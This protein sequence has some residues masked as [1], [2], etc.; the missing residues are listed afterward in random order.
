MKIEPSPDD[1]HEQHEAF[2]RSAAQTGANFPGYIVD[3]AGKR[4]KKFE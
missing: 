2:R 4:R 3:S 1:V